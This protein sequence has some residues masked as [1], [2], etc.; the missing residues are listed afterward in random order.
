MEQLV[1]DCQFLPRDFMHKRGVCRHAVSVCLCVC[2]MF[3]DH[4]KT[5]KY[6]FEIV[7]PSDSHTILVFPHQM[8]WRYS[9]GKPPTGA[10]NAGGIGR[11]RQSEPIYGFSACC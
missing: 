8:V 1:I 7:S 5:N 9:D 4:V 10:S 2:V 3:V 6:I 11:N